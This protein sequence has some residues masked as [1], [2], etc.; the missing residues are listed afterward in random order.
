[1]NEEQGVI[2]TRVDEG[3]REEDD[4]WDE[5]EEEETWLVQWFCAMDAKSDEASK[6]AVSTP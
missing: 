4:E 1:M 3:S 5:K 2:V 6:R